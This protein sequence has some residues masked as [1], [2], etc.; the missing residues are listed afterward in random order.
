MYLQET[1]FIA[2]YSDPVRKVRVH[3]KGKLWD[4]Y[5]NC[6]KNPKVKSSKIIKT[7]TN[8]PAIVNNTMLKDEEDLFEDCRKYLLYNF[9]KDDV[10]QEKWDQS[11]KYRQKHIMENFDAVFDKWPIFLK[12][13]ATELVMF[14]KNIFETRNYIAIFFVGLFGF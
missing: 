6:I 9:E 2:G 1:Y 7:T 8:E 10:V 3:N 5:T 14:I 13:Y 12:P 4:R 11:F